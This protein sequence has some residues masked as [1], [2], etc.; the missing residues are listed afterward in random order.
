MYRHE[1]H[2]G[3]KFIRTSG[4]CVLLNQEAPRLPAVLAVL[5]LVDEEKRVLVK[6][7]QEEVLQLGAGSLGLVPLD[8][9]GL[10]Y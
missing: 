7:L 2:H 10:Q 9:A 5:S 6:D 8:V 1:R 4:R 3:V